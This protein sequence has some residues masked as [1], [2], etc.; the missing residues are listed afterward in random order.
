ML[1]A[2]CS[3]LRKELP[4]SETAK[5]VP[6]WI[7]APY[8]GCSEATELCA[9]GES[10]TFAEA[11]AHSRANLAS[12]FQV[13]VKSDLTLNQAATASMPW[14]GSVREDVQRT[15][16]ESVNEMLETVQIK[17]RYK[18]DGLSYALAS[19]DRTKASELVGGRIQKIDSELEVLW[20]RR[21]RTNLRKI[22][23]LVLEREK[24]NERYS[25]VSGQ[26]RPA[27]V[28][29]ADVVAW[30]ETRP[31]SEPIVLRVGQA[32]DWM[33]EKLKELLTE[34]GFRFVKE[35]TEKILA[36]HVD[37]IKEY[38]NVDG[39]EK[40]TFTMSLA[41][42]ADGDKKKVIQ[43][44]ETVTGRSQADALLKVKHYFSEY[45]EQHI[46]DLHLD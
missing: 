34:A 12:I 8:E 33:V 41:S 6:A 19:L 22:V 4:V 16:K 37:S 27:S 44:S 36:L 18:K 24:L 20:A 38:M 31:K 23:R 39:F 29:Y 14:Q 1:V 2:G 5:E 35:N 3:N 7:Y 11:D 26:G 21:S 40:H 46:S 28:T 42:I 15:L 13:E 17:N 32:P 10:K 30:R 43:A 45:L 9:T 25:I